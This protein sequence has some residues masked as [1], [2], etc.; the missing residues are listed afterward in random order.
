MNDGQIMKKK[1][2]KFTVESDSDEDNQLE[3][4][5]RSIT[6][7]NQALGDRTR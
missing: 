7:T 4:M 1:R 5:K 2:Q 3:E 6:Q